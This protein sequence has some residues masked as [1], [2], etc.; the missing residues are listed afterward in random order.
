MDEATGSLDP[1]S[2]AAVMNGY[3]AL[4]P[5]RTLVLITHRRDLARRAERVVVIERGRVVEDGPPAALEG[6]RGAY[7]GIFHDGL[8]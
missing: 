3:E 2:E 5:G 6:A 7:A 8:G 4:A 1:R